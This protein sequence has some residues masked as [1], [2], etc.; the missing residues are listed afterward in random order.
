MDAYKKGLNGAQAV[1]AN[2]KYHGHCVLP[3][4]I[5]LITELD[6]LREK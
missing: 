6:A 4:N 2:Q 5:L 1:W 3:E